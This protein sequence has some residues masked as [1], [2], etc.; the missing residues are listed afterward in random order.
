LRAAA[1]PRFL[2]ANREGASINYLQAKVASVSAWM[3]QYRL[4]LECGSILLVAFIDRTSYRELGIGAGDKV[5]VSFCP[6]NVHTIESQST[7]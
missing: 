3:F 4:A 7:D 2:F 5:T 6:K 1:N